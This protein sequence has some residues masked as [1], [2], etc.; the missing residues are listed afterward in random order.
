MQLLITEYMSLK[1]IFLDYIFVADSIDLSLTTFAVRN[2]IAP[3]LPNS[4]QERKSKVHYTKVYLFTSSIIFKARFPALRMQR[5]QHHARII[6]CIKSKQR[7]ATSQAEQGPKLGSQ[8]K[9]NMSQF[10]ANNASLE[11]VI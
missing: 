2:V 5:T 10:G 11:F 6:A 8:E 1:T 9:S 3:K 7:N 4:V